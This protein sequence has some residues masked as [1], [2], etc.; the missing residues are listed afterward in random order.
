METIGCPERSITSKKSEQL[1]PITVWVFSVTSE[2][3]NGGQQ[4]Y[5]YIVNLH[6]SNQ[7]EEGSFY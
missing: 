5:F 1:T 7:Q 4:L 6:E 2:V 3:G